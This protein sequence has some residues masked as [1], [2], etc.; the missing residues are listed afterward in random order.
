MAREGLG[1][2]VKGS[3][4]GWEGSD[5]AGRAR[6]HHMV[7]ERVGVAEAPRGVSEPPLGRVPAAVGD[8]ERWGRV[9][10]G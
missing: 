6:A 3:G 8:G 4:D 2:Y 7:S 10:G 1:C 5:G 9:V